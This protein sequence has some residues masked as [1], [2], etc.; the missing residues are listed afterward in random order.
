MTI[1]V[2]GLG[3][4][5]GSVLHAFARA[6]HEVCGYD[7]DPAT[8]AAAR[9]AAESSPAARWRVAS[10]IRDAVAGADVVVVAVPLPAVAAVF[11]ELVDA[12]YAGLVTDVTS[13]KEPVR[14]LAADRLHRVARFIGGH[15]MA[16]R[17]TSGF[18]A[19]DPDL[20]TGCAWVL[21]LDAST[22]LADWLHLAALLTE[23]LGARVVPATAAEHDRAVATISHVPHLLASALAA[24]AGAN[25]LAATLG[26]GSFRDGTRVAAS[27]PELVAAMCGGN[28]PAVREALDAVLDALRQARAALDT[29]D[30]ITA[31]RPWLQPGHLTRVSW[32]PAPGTREELPAHAEALLQLGRAG[33]WITAVAPDRRTVTAVRPTAPIAG[34]AC[35]GTVTEA[36]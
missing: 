34:E 4:I 29:A 36:R 10:S 20:F 3:L 11:D 14:A 30:P 33:G 8:R 18:A 5:G 28:A 9:A 31:L 6:G 24:T 16:G 12:G 26:A 27:R 35:R 32:P 25:P 2:I 7:A 19:A 17:E 1:A 22:A 23:S 13:V 15:P 21:C